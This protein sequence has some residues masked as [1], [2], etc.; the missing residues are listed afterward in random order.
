[1]WAG[2]EHKGV[3]EL[4]RFNH[5][6]STTIRPTNPDW[7]R[8]LDAEKE[9]EGEEGQEA[10]AGMSVKKPSK[11]EV[12]MHNVTRIPF[13]SW[14]EHCVKGG[15]KSEGHK[16]RIE[17][18][19]SEVSEF[20]MDYMWMTEKKERKDTST[21][22]EAPI[23][24]QKDSK[25]RAIFAAFVSTRGKDEYAVKHVCMNLDWLGHKRV[26][27]RSDQENSIEDLIQEV[28]KRTSV[29]ITQKES[30]VGESQSNGFIERA[31]QE[32]Q[33]QTRIIKSAFESKLGVKLRRDHPISAWLVIHAANVINRFRVGNDGRTAYQRVTGKK[34]EKEV[35]EFGEVVWAIRP[36]SRGVTKWD[37]RWYEGIWVGVVNRSGEH[38]VLTEE[39]AAR[40][41]HV[42]RKPEDERWRSRILDKV[43]GVPWEP[44]PGKGTLQIPVKVDIPE[45]ER[46]MAGGE[47]EERVVERRRPKIIKQDVEKLGPTP[48]CNAYTKQMVGEPLMGVPHKEE[49][50]RRHES[51]MSKD[52]DP[53]FYRAFEKLMEEDE[54][55]M[56]RKSANGQA[57]EER[58]N[59][60]RRRMD[61]FIND[62]SR[63]EDTTPGFASSGLYVPGEGAARHQV[64]DRPEVGTGPGERKRV[65][66]EDEGEEVRHAKTMRREE[67]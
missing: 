37:Y 36:K 58:E 46:D 49:C 6:G 66:F 21:G 38:V 59:R 26:T 43:K 9:E 25:T 39:G 67:L 33:K 4:S 2:V 19:S 40:T 17:E 11:K 53:S 23:L 64:A 54:E 28:K 15:A 55:V 30:P 27:I 5:F 62:R 10:K 29:E 14:C 7:I 48:G 18:E 24:V 47:N 44:V 63:N 1:M 45:T 51:R 34:F 12:E 50:R 35:V 57:N 20:G 65:R 22:L 13:R 60:K 56:K 8:G 61:G 32:V 31:I 41:P 42:R 3:R 16:A 52:E